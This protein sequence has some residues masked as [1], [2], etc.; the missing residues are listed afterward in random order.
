LGVKY[1]DL[2]RRTKVDDAVFELLTKEYEI[3]KIQEVREAHTAEVLDVADLPEKKSSP[4]RLLII[5]AGAF[6]G[7]FF[8]SIWVISRRIWEKTDSQDP[9]KV[10]AQAVF[11]RVKVRTWDTRLCQKGYTGAQRLVRWV[12]RPET[13][14]QA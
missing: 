9:R 3:A 12:H 2:Y 8:A 13:D 5:L 14:E 11:C 4:H 6:L 1:L 7:T 10:L